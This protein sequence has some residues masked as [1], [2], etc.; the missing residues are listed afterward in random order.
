MNC[1]NDRIGQRISSVH[2]DLHEIRVFF[3][4]ASFEGGTRASYCWPRG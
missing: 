2:A 3:A 1:G 4:K